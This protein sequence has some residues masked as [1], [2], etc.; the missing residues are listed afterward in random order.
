MAS[1]STSTST[2]SSTI[3]RCPTTRLW[4]HLRYVLRLR[5]W[6]RALPVD[7]LLRSGVRPFYF[8]PVTRSKRRVGDFY[9]SLDFIS[10]ASRLWAGGTRS[11]R[12]FSPRLR[13][14]QPR[15]QTHAYANGSV[16]APDTHTWIEGKRLNCI[17]YVLQQ[18]TIWADRR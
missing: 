9:D 4:R 2:S 8:F 17:F 11:V 15:G 10:L 16:F 14:S 13:T 6:W 12:S 18:R 1:T 5:P 3:L 7:E